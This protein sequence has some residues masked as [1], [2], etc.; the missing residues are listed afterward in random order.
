MDNFQMIRVALIE[1]DITYAIGLKYYLKKFDDINLCGT[2]FDYDDSI[3]LLKNTDFDIILVNSTL[4]ENTD[5]GLKLS[6]EL[7]S[8]YNSK[9]I[10]LTP[11]SNNHKKS[12]ESNPFHYI[13][14]DNYSEIPNMIRD[15]Y[16]KKC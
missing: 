12:I 2:A 7:K 9:I 10:I 11:L 14:K 1:D 8:N 13:C 16:Y 6:K 4:S 15:I 3:N 5:T